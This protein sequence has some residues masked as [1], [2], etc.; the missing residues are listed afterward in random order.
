MLKLLGIAIIYNVLF[1]LFL[2]TWITEED[3]PGLPFYLVDKFLYLLYFNITTF[4]S[5]GYG[6]ITPKTTRSRMIMSLYMM[7]IFIFVIYYS[8]QNNK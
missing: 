6:D 5:T 1:T 4:T 3:I 8:S 2:M 7:I